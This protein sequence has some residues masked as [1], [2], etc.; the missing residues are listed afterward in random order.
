M[1]LFQYSPTSDRRLVKS[2]AIKVSLSRHVFSIL[3][4]QIIKTMMKYRDLVFFDTSGGL[5]PC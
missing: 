5:P 4:L 1:T 2:S 3:L